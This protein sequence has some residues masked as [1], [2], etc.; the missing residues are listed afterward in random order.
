MKSSRWKEFW[1]VTLHAQ[2]RKSME[3][4][5][6]VE[7]LLMDRFDFAVISHCS[8]LPLIISKLLLWPPCCQVAMTMTKKKKK[9]LVYLQIN[10]G[11]VSIFY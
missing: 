5:E 4:G 7:L 2:M 9:S 10:Q 1:T 3:K 6:E 8:L 11:I